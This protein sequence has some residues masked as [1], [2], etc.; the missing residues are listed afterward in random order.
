MG[1]LYSF[2]NLFN[3]LVLILLLIQC[4]VY[5]LSSDCVLESIYQGYG[6]KSY[7]LT[8]HQIS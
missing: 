1:L 6:N 8:S 5:S 4:L 7:L 3:D 2:N